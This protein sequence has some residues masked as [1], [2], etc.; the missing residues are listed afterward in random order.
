MAYAILEERTLETEQML[1]I[2]QMRKTELPQDFSKV[3][4][5]LYLDK[6]REIDLDAGSLNV[7][8][9]VKQYARSLRRS[10]HLVRDGKLYCSLFRD[11]SYVYCPNCPAYKTK[12]STTIAASSEFPEKER[13]MHESLMQV[14]LSR[15]QS[16]LK[17]IRDE[18]EARK[19]EMPL[20]KNRASIR[21]STRRPKGRSVNWKT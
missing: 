12:I 10:A 19:N 16:N 18:I 7:W 11:S 15:R 1:E 14:F 17:K 9:Q 5:S 8:Q 3:G 21:Y 4:C 20:E 6:G 13:S 2:G